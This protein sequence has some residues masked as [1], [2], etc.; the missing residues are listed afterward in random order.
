M[1][2]WQIW[3]GLQ[4]PRAGRQR[5]DRGAADASFTHE[6]WAETDA[7]IVGG[8]FGSLHVGGRFPG[9]GEVVDLHLDVIAVR[10]L[11]VQRGCDTVLGCDTLLDGHFRRYVLCLKCGRPLKQ[12]V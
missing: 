6:L 10:I 1:K 12:V 4:G 2:W 8:V 3:A 7:D 5:V 11:V 9:R